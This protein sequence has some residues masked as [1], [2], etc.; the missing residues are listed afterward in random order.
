MLEILQDDSLSTTEKVNQLATG[1]VST[2]GQMF[3]AV[4]AI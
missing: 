2:A 1:I 4:T 3:N